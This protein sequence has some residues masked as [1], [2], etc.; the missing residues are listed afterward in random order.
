MSKTSTRN[1]MRKAR[2]Q[3]CSAYL[4]HYVRQFPDTVLPDV[5]LRFLTHGHHERD[6][7]K[8]MAAHAA[9]TSGFI[10]PEHI[11][12]QARAMFAPVQAARKWRN[13]VKARMAE[14]KRQRLARRIARRA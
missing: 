1:T 12:K 8:F 6:L 7:H 3:R 2:R 10:I 11:K 9:A 14:A 5:A 4:S 13:T